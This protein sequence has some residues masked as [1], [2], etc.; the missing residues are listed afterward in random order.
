MI[1][2]LLAI[3]LVARLSAE[4]ASD[5]LRLRS[6]HDSAVQRAVRP[7]EQSY[8]QALGRLRATY[9]AAGHQTEVQQVDA[10]SKLVTVW[11]GFTFSAAATSSI[12]LAKEPHAVDLGVLRFGD[13]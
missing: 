10:K 13:L 9:T 12:S 3:P 7:L 6:A 5:L 11:S 4:A 8:Q 1:S 2:C